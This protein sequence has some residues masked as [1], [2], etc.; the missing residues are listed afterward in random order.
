MSS[1]NTKLLT[2]RF[3]KIYYRPA[4]NRRTNTVIV[5]RMVRLLSVEATK[6]IP[7]TDRI[8]LEISISK[9]ANYRIVLF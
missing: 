6:Y 4:I 1:V 2:L 3:F 8:P 7:P 9:A 5:F